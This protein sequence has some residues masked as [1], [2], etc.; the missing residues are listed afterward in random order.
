MKSNIRFG[1]LWAL[2]IAGLSGCQSSR[3]P[4]WFPPVATYHASPV[5]ALPS[6]DSVAQGNILT[7]RV[8]QEPPVLTAALPVEQASAE[9]PV[10]NRPRHLPIAE[11]FSEPLRQ[12]TPP[13]TISSQRSTRPTPSQMRDGDILNTV[14][15]VVG[16]ILLI[17]AAVLI[18]ASLGATGWGALTAFFYGIL[19]VCFAL[20]FL[21]FKSRKSTSYVRRQ[22]ARAARRASKGR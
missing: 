21:L 20:P 1:A 3:L 18:I 5:T 4:G 12:A 13:D 10:I 9:T 16:V 2:L 7:A 19:F 14:I 15:H 6:S 17:T 22:E 11:V 8:P